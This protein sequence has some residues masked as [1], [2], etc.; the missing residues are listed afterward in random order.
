MLEIQ[1]LSVLHQ[2]FIAV[3]YEAI[4]LPCVSRSVFVEEFLH[5]LL[6]VPERFYYFF[7]G[8]YFILNSAYVLRMSFLNHFLNVSLL[9]D[10][11]ECFSDVG[12][13]YQVIELLYLPP[14]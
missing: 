1:L 3:T 5:L 4:E 10:L 14:V 6:L 8:L 7:F 12:R 9:L 2:R 13:D 11:R